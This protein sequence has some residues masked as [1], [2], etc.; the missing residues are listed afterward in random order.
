MHR[1]SWWVSMWRCAA[2]RCHVI[3]P[4]TSEIVT[5]GAHLLVA[6]PGHRPG[7]VTEPDRGG[8]HRFRCG[9]W[10]VAGHRRRKRCRRGLRGARR[11]GRDRNGVAAR[12]RLCRPRAQRLLAG[13]PPVRGEHPV[14]AVIL[15]RCR[16]ARRRGPY[17]RDSRRRQ[18]SLITTAD[19]DPRQMIGQPAR[20]PVTA[21]A[22]RHPPGADVSY[23]SGERDLYA[24]PPLSRCRRSWVKPGPLPRLAACPLVLDGMT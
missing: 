7:A 5:A 2:W 1:S 14:V 9:R 4:R 11:G 13:T 6:A 15:R 12:C 16:L 8:L 18:V 23:L 22:R 19:A 21:N 10:Q 17:R 20:R 24:A 3:R